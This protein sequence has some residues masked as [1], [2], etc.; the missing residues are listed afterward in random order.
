MTHV[1]TFNP[2]AAARSVV[3]FPV[4]GA[5]TEQQ[6]APKQ[7]RQPPQAEVLRV[8]GQNRFRYLHHNGA[9]YAVPYDGPPIA[10]PLRAAAHTGTGSLRQH[11]T[12]AYVTEHDRTPSQ[13]ALADTLAALDALAMRAPETELHL[14][15]AA[16]P[17]DT[18]VSWLDLGRPDGESVRLAPDGWALTSPDPETGPIWRRSKLVRSLPRPDRSAGGWRE[19]IEEFAELLPFTPETL[20]LAVGWLL[21]ALR[22][23]MP[24]PIAYLTGEQGTGKSTSGQMLAGIIEGARAPLRQ[25]PENLRDLGPT[26]AAGWVLALDNLSGLPGWLSDALCRI[27]TGDAQ[28]TRALYTDDD[29]NVL[30][31][32]RP[33]L[34]TGIDLGALRNDLAERMLPLELQPIPRHKRRTAGSLWATYEQAHPRILGALLDLAVAVWADLPHAAADLAERPR[35]AD[36]AELLHALDRV[37]GW[38]SLAAFNGAQD[39]L[40]DAVLDGHPVAGALREWTE[41]PGFPPGGWQGTMA[42]LHRQLGSDGRGL[43][44]GWP[45]TPAVLSARIRQVAPALRARGIQVA[46]TSGSNKHGKVYAVTRHPTP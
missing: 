42:E 19:G 40:N 14:R 27:V 41:S 21:A 46:R 10:V 22:P 45:K 38:H 20:P 6:R 2:T 33:V 12:Y 11:L 29:V 35:L 26:T 13:T 4:Q 34:L 32:Q 16:D 8:L 17:E 9:P 7:E 23:E 44:D 1:P 30:T 3:P 5:G 25:A 28:V 36:F 15:V 18:A 24:R 43:G 39:A 37:T 31:Y